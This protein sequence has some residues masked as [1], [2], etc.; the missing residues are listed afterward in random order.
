VDADLRYPSV[1]AYFGLPNG[2]GLVDYLSGNA[3]LPDLLV[4]PQGFDKLVLLPGGRPAAGGAELIGSPM[5]ANL[6]RELKHFYP[7]RYVLFD[8]PPLLSFADPLA[9]APLVDAIILVVERAKTPREG[10]KKCVEVLKGFPVLG[11][12]LNKAEESQHECYYYYSHKANGRPGK[13]G[14]LDWIKS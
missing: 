10:I 2:P 13:K 5:M 3:S 7:D 14:I 6:V 9:F 4:H 11:L 1:H 12:V 8:L